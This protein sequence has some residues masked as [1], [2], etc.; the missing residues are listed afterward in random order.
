LKLA[1]LGAFAALAA[2][3]GPSGDPLVIYYTFNPGPEQRCEVSGDPVLTCDQIPVT[4]SSVAL[5]RIVD[6]DD[7][8]IVYDDQCVSL[9]QLSAPNLCSLNRAGLAS[10]DAFPTDRVEVQLAIYRLA[11]LPDSTI[12]EPKCPT[13]VE[14]TATGFAAST[15][16]PRPALAGKAYTTGFDSNVTI[17]LGCNEI[18][19]LN[20]CSGAD[21]LAL[22]STVYDFELGA[23][24]TPEVADTLTINGTE[25][26]S[27]GSEDWQVIQDQVTRLERVE[28]PGDPQWHADELVP[29]PL[30]YVCIQVQSQD[31]G[32]TLAC[33]AL[34]VIRPEEMDVQGYRVDPA[35]IEMVLEAAGLAAVPESGLVIGIVINTLNGAPL[36]GFEVRDS[37]S[38]AIQYLSADGESLGGTQTTASGI[39]ISTVAPFE[40]DGGA[41]KWT[42]ANSVLQQITKPVGGLVRNH[43]SVM[44]IE[45]MP[46]AK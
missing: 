18:Y 2:S 35:T 27:D 16:E 3:C 15:N 21:A 30:E 37:A 39:F 20:A 10:G 46:Q 22:T 42:I 40:H 5:L 43:V 24:V 17:Y 34:P 4:C 11:D 9:D 32:S 33:Q 8:T 13:H 14:F 6:P 31:T 41:N 36:S 45:L 25:P 28:G 12:E 38:S 26:V 7:P 44:V 29:S 19:R 23:S 1:A